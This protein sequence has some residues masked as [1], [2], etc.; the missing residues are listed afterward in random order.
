MKAAVQKQCST[1]TLTKWNLEVGTY[2][3]WQLFYNKESFIF[4]MFIVTCLRS[5]DGQ[6]M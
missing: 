4:C 6:R 1:N 2:R 5:Y 3:K